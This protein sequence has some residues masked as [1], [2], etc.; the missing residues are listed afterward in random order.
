MDVE[1]VEAEVISE[2]IVTIDVD[3]G[4]DEAGRGKL[5]ILVEPSKEGV[6][7]DGGGLVGVEDGVALETLE[8]YHVGQQGLCQ[9]Y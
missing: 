4:Q 8:G 7:L 5:G 6:E 2:H 1:P 3:D 9:D